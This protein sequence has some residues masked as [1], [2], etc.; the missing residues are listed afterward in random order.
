M[1]TW[2]ELF[3][4]LF[5]ASLVWVFSVHSRPVQPVNVES[6]PTANTARGGI[7]KTDSGGE[8]RPHSK[9]TAPPIFSPAGRLQIHALDFFFPGYGL[10]KYD[11]PI[12]GSLVAAG[13]ISTIPLAY[14]FHRT[15]N[16]YDSLARA[17]RNAEIY[18]GPGLV[19][20]DP[21]HGGYK[22]REKMERLA[23]RNRFYAGLSISFHLIL[24][25][26]SQWKTHRGIELEIEKK[27]PEFQIPVNAQPGKQKT[28]IDLP[29]RDRDVHALVTLAR[30]HRAISGR[31]TAQAIAPGKQ[32]ATVEFF[33]ITL[34]DF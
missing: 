28:G 12:Q 15:A 2:I 11:R 32:D 14:Q 23:D 8:S 10:F 33:R 3:A 20:Y 34:L 26:Y 5:I 29:Y 25:L 6:K 27:I 7:A 9:N 19:Y 13:R 21:I 1:K 16:E 4:A 30:G 24:L 18:Y 17:A 22:S 31:F